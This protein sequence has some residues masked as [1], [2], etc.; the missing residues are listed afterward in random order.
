MIHRSND[1]CITI[2]HTHNKLPPSSRS[3]LSGCTATV[4]IWYQL[5][6]ETPDPV[7]LRASYAF[8]H[9]NFEEFHDNKPLVKRSVK[10]WQRI[11]E[12]TKDNHPEAR[13]TLR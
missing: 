9:K 11:R 7:L 6:V 8:W 13:T 2:S 3:V 10:M 4:N 12:W 5:P 1:T